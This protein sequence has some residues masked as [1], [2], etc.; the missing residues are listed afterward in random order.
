MT[1]FLLVISYV[2]GLYFFRNNWPL[3]I[4]I[5]VLF[6]IYLIIRIGLKRL[7]TYLF[8]FTLGISTSAIIHYVNPTKE[9][10]SGMVVESSE[11]YFIFQSGIFRFYVYE[12][13]TEK[14]FGDF[15][16]IYDSPKE[17][18]FTTYESQFDFNAYLKDKGVRYSLSIYKCEEK[19]ISLVRIKKA[20][21]KFLNSFDENTKYLLNAF[22]FA[23]KD[24][25][26]T[27]LSNAD[28]IGLL[29]LFSV[30]GIYLSFV[31][32][33]LKKIFRLI[34]HN[35]LA[36]ILPLVIFVP[37]FVFIFPKIGVIRV[38][39]VY[40]FKYINENFLNKK[41]SYI[42]IISLLAA[43]FLLINPTYAYQAGFYL[44]FMLSAYIYF[45]GDIL[46]KYKR[47][48]KKII[49][50]LLI[51]LFMIP[52]ASF[53]G[54]TF[55]LF[56][57]IFQTISIPINEIYFITSLI[58]LYTAP[59]RHVLKFFSDILGE[60]Y[61]FFAYIDVSISLGQFSEFY[62]LIYYLLLLYCLY[63]LESGRRPHLIKVSSVLSTL[64]VVSLLPIRTYL[65]NAIYFINVG[66]GD[67]ILIQN[68]SH[69]VM[70]DTGGNQ[71]FD[72]AK[73]TLI[74]FLKKRQ[75]YTLDALITTHSDF[76]H[77]GAAISLIENFNVKT[78]L[79]NRNDFPYKVGDIY[80]E[81]LNDFDY[82]DNNDSSL[83]FNLEFMNK[84][85]LFLGDASINIEKKLIDKYIDLD[86]DIIKIGHH[87]SN[88]STCEA[89]IKKITPN[90]AIISLGANNNYG[91]PSKEVINIL[92]K[93]NVKVRRTDLEGT[94]S[95]INYFF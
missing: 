66:Q 16:V 85:W 60:I 32:N 52:I 50:R 95:Y 68:K 71:K 80:L 58:S 25:S 44:G 26:N 6:V 29:F 7:P 67:S 30:S 57:L 82:D 64:F 73:E 13:E 78:Y 33:G 10:Y 34:L 79:S 2:I 62:V 54:G 41:F 14:Q 9:S 91:H 89:L 63:L 39:S 88:T 55:H 27:T 11:N 70:I 3:I 12:K 77:S 23:H 45:I 61:S 28:E 19:F 74:P 75:I 8:V 49:M 46:S 21:D 17:I 92:N 5:S 36:D 53:S 51:Y 43:L 31:L 22:L 20:K 38:F 47:L 69:A 18:N 15:L 35:K 42:K 87:G 56:S 94:I 1:I 86:T 72:M 65:T 48:K 76:D 90:E 83:V 93:Y 24:T 81:N 37:Y 84:K 59:F 40:I 4:V